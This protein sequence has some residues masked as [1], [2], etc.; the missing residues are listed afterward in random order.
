M[1]NSARRQERFTQYQGQRSDEPAA[2]GVVARLRPLLDRADTAD[3]LGDL[4]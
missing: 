4:R 3:V 1:V 2:S